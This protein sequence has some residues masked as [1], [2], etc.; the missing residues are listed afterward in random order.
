MV[1]PSLRIHAALVGLVALACACAAPLQGAFD[2]LHEVPQPPPHELDAIRVSD[3]DYEDFKRW[4]SEWF[5]GETFGGERSVT[6]VLGL[7]NGVVE[8]PCEAGPPGCFRPL[9]VFDLFVKALDDLDHVEGNLFAGDGMANGGPTGEGYTSDLVIRFPR[10]TRLLGTIPVPEVLHTGLDVEAG[11]RWPLGIVEVDA[12]AEEQT[13][14][15]RGYLVKVPAALAGAPGPPTRMRLGLTCALCH[16]SL[17]IDGDGRADLKSARLGS[18]PSARYRP[19]HAWGIG[20]QDLSFGWL[21][22]LSANPLTAFTVLSGPIGSTD[23][24]DARAFTRWIL[25]NRTRAPEAVMRQAVVSVLTH[26]RGS[27]DDTPDGL[28]QAVQMPSIYTWRNW[29]YNT[30]GALENA[31]D[32]NN[33]VWTGSIDFTGLVGLASDRASALTPPW[34]SATIFT[35]MPARTYAELI[36]DHA[37]AVRYDPSLQHGLIE[38][39]LGESDGVP[40]MLDPDAIAVLSGG[41]HA[42]PD[43]IFAM[44]INAGRRRTPADY[45]GDAAARAGTLAVFGTRVRTPPHIRRDPEYHFDDLVAKYGLNADEFFTDVVSLTLNWQP[46]P[47]NL[48]PLLDGAWDMI[49]RGWS[50]FRE[51]RCATCHRG[52]FFTDN[53]VQRLSAIEREEFGISPPSTAGWMLPGRDLGP[54]IGTDPR[55]TL[56]TRDE[57]IFLSPLYDPKTG[58]ATTGAGQ[59]TGFFRDQ[60]VGYKTSTLR[61]LWS[62]PPYLHDG[63]VGVTFPSDDDPPPADLRQRLR[64]AQTD[65]RVVY[66]MGTILGAFEERQLNPRRHADGTPIVEPWRRPDPALSLQALLLE[67]ERRKIVA[68]NRR[69]SVRVPPGAIDLSGDPGKPA[70][71]WIPMVSLGVSGIGHEFWVDDVPGGDRITAL[72]AFLLALDDKPCELPNGSHCLH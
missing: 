15:K 53:R 28:H 34:E 29:P 17:D 45:G 38:D 6:D 5:R 65:P 59:V 36:T 61:N 68:S 32:R 50:V 67:S 55:R 14:P 39:I 62:T 70:P 3:A 16:Y 13:D 63:S 47:P 42:M 37:P 31:S 35:L 44:P 12:P 40:G 58:K 19:E 46:P 43:D 1:T 52:P 10:G 71:E 8:V 9:S 48:S 24:R 57:E 18:P 49:E 64:A 4:G 69:S 23:P 2:V 66:G 33:V 27:A 20:N 60:R 7:M 41:S 51:A 54:A 21:L 22:A 56:G 72:V 30:D 25:D 26:P 11:Q